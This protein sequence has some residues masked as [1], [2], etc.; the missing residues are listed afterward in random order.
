MDNF[1]LNLPDIVTGKVIPSSIERKN[2]EN[3]EKHKQQ[4][5]QNT[6]TIIALALS[7]ISIIV[8]IAALIISISN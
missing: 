2:A 7:S 8:S 1:N 3:A 5:F 4:K 6:T